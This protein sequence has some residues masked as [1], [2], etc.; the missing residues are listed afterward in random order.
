MGVRPLSITV[1][2]CFVMLALA[3]GC[4]QAPTGNEGT[5]PATP[6]AVTP[7]DATRPSDSDG[8]T[9]GT[10]GAPATLGGWKVTVRQAEVGSGNDDVQVESGMTRLE[11]EVDLENTSGEPL[12]VAPGDWILVD[13]ADASYSVLPSSRP[14]KQG[15]RTIPAGQTEDVSVNFA[16][17]SAG[18]PFMLRFAPSQGADGALEVPI[19]NGA[20]TTAPKAEDKPEDSPSPGYSY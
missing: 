7:E 15:E 14:E 6:E 17:P 12:A 20:A 11:V 2:A 5:T 8:V 18:G 16:V 3:V 4:S 13:A 19:T 1:V 10:K 9:T